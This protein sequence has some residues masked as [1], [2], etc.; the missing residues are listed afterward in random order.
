LIVF[1]EFNAIFLG[2]KIEKK[3]EMPITLDEA[4]CCRFMHLNEECLFLKW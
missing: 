2:A 4:T 1:R 3:K